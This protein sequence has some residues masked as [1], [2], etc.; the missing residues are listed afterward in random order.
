LRVMHHRFSRACSHLRESLKIKVFEHTENSKIHQHKTSP[1]QQV[2][3]IMLSA[4]GENNRKGY[5]LTVTQ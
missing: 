2:C 4:L 3:S 1:A 5:Q